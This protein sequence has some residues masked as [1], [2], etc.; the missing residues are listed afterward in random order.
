MAYA[1]KNVAEVRLLLDVWEGQP[2]IP[3][4]DLQSGGIDGVIMRINHISGGNH[5][6]ALFQQAWQHYAPLLR[7]IY[8]VY[9][10]WISGAA[11]FNWLALNAP[12]DVNFISVDVEVSYPALLTV[13]KW[14]SSKDFRSAIQRSTKTRMGVRGAKLFPSILG[15]V[16]GITADQ[17]A[18]DVETFKQYATLKWK[19]D[20]CYSGGGFVNLLSHWPHDIDYWWA[21]YVYALY[22]STSV[23][24]T[25]E[26]LR[27][28]LLTV[29]W[30]PSTYNL[31]PGPL[32][33]WQATGDRIKLPGTSNRPA[34]IN[35]F[36]GSLNDL[37]VWMG[38][39]PLPPAEEYT[40]QEMLKI[41]WREAGLHN[42]NLEGPQP[43]G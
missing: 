11:N 3:I 32:R 6:D 30:P 41:L 36:C 21:N 10:P 18:V 29:S 23:S 37:R 9:N 42:W 2:L 26:Q 8:Y 17:Y 35:I 27:A 20:V 5:Y 40:D 1:L 33:L 24:M 38:Y 28:A 43:E 22:P 12:K 16:R 34:D 4:A 19:K 14:I 39:D 7:G 13:A 31:C 15:A 25:W